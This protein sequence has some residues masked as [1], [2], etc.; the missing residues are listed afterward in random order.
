MSRTPHQNKIEADFP[1]YHSSFP[2]ADVSP[3]GPRSALK[4]VNTPPGLSLFTLMSSDASAL[5]A[6]SQ[7]HKRSHSAVGRTGVMDQQALG[8]SGGCN[9]AGLTMKPGTSASAMNALQIGMDS[10]RSPCFV[11]KTFGGSIN[12]ER[13]LDE[14]RAEEMT[15]HNLLQTATGVREVARQLGMPTEFWPD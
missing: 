13:V 7:N 1:I 14:C 10:M 11:H 2:T 8:A 9:S 3:T 6:K 4:R 15:H 5:A 12:L